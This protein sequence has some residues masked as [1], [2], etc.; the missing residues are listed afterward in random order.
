MARDLNDT[1]GLGGSSARLPSIACGL[2]LLCQIERF[3]NS[4]DFKPQ[5]SLMRLGG[6]IGAGASALDH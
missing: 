3:A 4:I 2:R 6:R 5:L 1:D